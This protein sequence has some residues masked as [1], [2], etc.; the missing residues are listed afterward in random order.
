[1]PQKQGLF[2]EG[3]RNDLL[4]IV[5]NGDLNAFKPLFASTWLNLNILCFIN[6]CN[7]VQ[8]YFQHYFSWLVGYFH[9]FIVATGCPS[10]RCPQK[11][12]SCY[13]DSARIQD[14]TTENFTWFFKVISVQHRHTG[15][16]FNV[17]SERLL[18]IF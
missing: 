5:N 6:N 16:R 9:L 7:D 1:M 8:H 2:K 15:P 3:L 12:V 10:E 17:S 14:E 18:M 13:G 11:T 4:G